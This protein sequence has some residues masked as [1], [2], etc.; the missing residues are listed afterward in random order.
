MSTQ[1]VTIQVRD[2]LSAP[3]EGVRVEI[4]RLQYGEEIL[5]GSLVTTATGDAVFPI[6]ADGS[7]LIRLQKAGHTFSG[8]G[9]VV[10][11]TGLPQ[12]FTLTGTAVAVTLPATPP[13]C[14]LYGYLEGKTNADRV[15]VYVHRRA[16][17][18][19][20]SGTGVNPLQDQTVSETLLVVAR[21]RRWEVTLRQG[22]TV[23]VEIP[24]SRVDRS[25]LIPAAEMV[26]FTDLP[27]T[28]VATPSGRTGDAW[29]SK[30]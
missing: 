19:L 18:R 13:T 25:V 14:L 16:E 2:I 20:G 23:R 8:T 3:I 26:N 17:L 29:T 5:V 22:E 28:P 1:T 12:T 11:N 6:M 21:E 4:R 30:S 15:M 7:Y 27:S 24:D 10:A 9:F